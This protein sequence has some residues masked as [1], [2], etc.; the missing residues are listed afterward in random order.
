MPLP[1][2]GRV[3]LLLALFFLGSETGTRV[4]QLL[5][6]KDPS[7]VVIDELVGQWLTILPLAAPTTFELVAAFVLFRFFDIAKP[8]PVRASENW[9]PGGYGIM[10]DDVLAGIYAAIVLG[11]IHWLR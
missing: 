4:E 8:A 9:L 7:R 3:L 11:L 1:V 6:Q 10:I 5:G 2:W